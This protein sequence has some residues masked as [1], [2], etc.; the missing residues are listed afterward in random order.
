MATNAFCFVEAEIPIW[1]PLPQADC[2]LVRGIARRI[3][4]GGAS[5]RKKG[6]IAPQGKEQSVLES[7][8]V[9]AQLS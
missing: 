7:P 4:S 5:G 9:T 2:S 6:L 8:S 1:Q 3:P